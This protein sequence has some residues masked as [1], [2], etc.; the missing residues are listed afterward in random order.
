MYQTIVLGLGFLLLLGGGYLIKHMDSQGVIGSSIATPAALDATT[1]LEMLSGTYI[2]DVNSG[3]EN[4]RVL[5]LSSDGTVNMNTSYENGVEVVNETG[6]WSIGINTRP[7]ILLK[8]ASGTLYPTPRLF[9]VR[10]ASATS[11]SG[12]TFDEKAYPDLKK[13]VFRKDQDQLQ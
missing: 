3:C 11:L 5:T 2:C 8:G 10:Y 1:T 6:T 4:P 9:N 12:I 7:A 13:P